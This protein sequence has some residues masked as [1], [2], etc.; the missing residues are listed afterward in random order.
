MVSRDARPVDFC[1]R[2]GRLPFAFACQS[3]TGWR[4]SQLHSQGRSPRFGQSPARQVAGE[5]TDEV[6]F[7]SQVVERFPI[8]QIGEM[9]PLSARPVA[10]Q[11]VKSLVRRGVGCQSSQGR[12]LRCMMRE[13]KCVSYCDGSPDSRPVKSV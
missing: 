5:S 6:A 12:I 4:P 1:H 10:R 9:G 11:V 7:A 2:L 8:A 3:K 13:R